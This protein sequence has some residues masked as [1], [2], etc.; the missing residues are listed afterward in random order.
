MT[1]STWHIRMFGR[2][3]A[4]QGSR[5]LQRF[6]TQKTGLLLAYL[7]LHPQQAHAREMLAELFWPD[8]ERE[9][10]ATS[11]RVALTTLRRVLQSEDTPPGAVLIT[12]RASVR[13]NPD[14]YHTD[15]AAFEAALRQAAEVEGEDERIGF[16]RQAVDLY[17]GALLSGYEAL[18]I[19][20]ERQRLADAYL[21][22]LRHLV[23]DLARSQDFDTALEIAHRL[24]QADPLREESHRALMRLYAAVGRS[25]AALQHYQSLE[26]ILARAPSASTRD[27]ARQLAEGKEWNT[28]TAPAEV[29][30]PTSASVAAAMPPSAGALPST[31]TRFFG[32]QE[33]IR[34]LQSLLCSP[35]VRLV[36]L[37]GPGGSGK[38]RLAIEVA[39][40]I[41][42]ESTQAIWIV[43]LADVV[44]PGHIAGAILSALRLQRSVSLDPLDQVIAALSARPGLLVL[45][46]FEQ[47]A[48]D[49]APVVQA[50]LERAPSLTCLVTSRQRL[51]IGGEQ[52]VPVSPLPIPETPEPVSRLLQYP[53]VQLFVDR[54][55]AV[56]P[57]F[58]LTEQNAA[59][60]AALCRR[61]EGLP[62][63]IELAAAWAQTLT[64]AQMLSRLEKRFDLLVSHRKDL[65]ER[66]R[67]LWATLEGSL[68]LLPLRLRPFFARLSVFRGGWT[69]DAAEVVCEEPRALEALTQLKERSLVLVEEAGEEM[70][71]RLLETLREFAFEQLS[72]EERQMLADRHAAYFLQLA[73]DYG[74]AKESDRSALLDRQEREQDNLRAALDWR[75]QKDAAGGLKAMN[76][77]ND[78][79]TA[80]GHPR[81]GRERLL[82]YLERTEP[83]GTTPERAMAVLNA[84]RLSHF[85]GDMKQ[86]GRLFEQSRHMGQALEDK[87]LIA[88]ALNG[89]GE[90]AF[91]E[92]RLSAAADFHLQSLALWRAMGASAEIA[93]VLTHLGY[94]AICQEDYKTAPAYFLESLQIRRQLGDIS[95]VSNVLADLGYLAVCRQDYPE[96][97]AFYEQSLAIAREAG[98]QGKIAMRLWN[99]GNLTRIEG[100]FHRSRSLLEESQSLLQ[101]MGDRWNRSA[102]LYSWALVACEQGDYREA[103]SLLEE[104]VHLLKEL[105]RRVEDSIGLEVCAYLALGA[106]HPEQA[107]RMFG[108]AEAFREASEAHLWLPDN[109]RLYERTVDRVRA[110]MSEEA[111]TSAWRAGRALSLKQTIEDILDKDT[112][113]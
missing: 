84:G 111:F 98:D 96:A 88:C 58:V 5:V 25:A 97:H 49:G 109:R 106:G 79:W 28:A 1:D 99:L 48:D 64:P 92:G 15:V 55:Q 78:Y 90:V 7:A 20:P 56:H 50:L 13:L 19:E 37:L 31:L 24:V 100:Q 67:T 34:Q 17:T 46:N 74:E 91:H 29:V 53:S 103:R 2:L 30:S 57:G 61:L 102:V 44:D 73:E 72:E 36:T 21:G 27:L 42:K 45:D 9:A 76:V 108:A 65:P 83:L 8:E 4:Q 87:T 104:R 107:A 43:P 113:D 105:G 35:Q 110:A 89:L 18:W 85:L 94:T 26:E 86:A 33:E 71:F 23:R 16:L 6:R 51:N 12:D 47:L 82:A 75:L 68:R 22:A 40:R 3:Q 69:L 80:R 59:Q 39:A 81:E 54:A 62:L 14:A 66:H 38:S 41:G 95:A 11:L 77:L 63:A 10:A 52:V 112:M 32:R 70:R 101:E 60:V 93:V